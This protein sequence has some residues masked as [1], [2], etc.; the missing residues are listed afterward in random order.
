ME[1]SFEKLLVKLAEADVRFVVV[2]D[3]AVTLHGYT[4]FTEDIDLL[5]DQD[6]DNIQKLLD[7]LSEYG[8]GYA[9]ELLIDDFTDTEGAIRIIEE[10]EMCQ[11]DLFTRLSGKTYHDVTQDAEIFR[12]GRHEILYASKSSLIFWKGRSVREKDQMDARALELLQRDS[13]AFDD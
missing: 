11:I 4:R 10:R 1:P 2:D 13:K 12:I 9:K 8:D 5:I 3:I 6:S 7:I